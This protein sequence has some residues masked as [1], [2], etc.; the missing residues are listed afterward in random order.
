MQQGDE[1]YMLKVAQNQGVGLGCYVN[2]KTIL[3][4]FSKLSLGKSGYVSLVDQNGKNIVTVTE[5][6]I[7]RDSS[8]LD[9]GNYTFRQELS[10][11][12]FEIQIKISWTGVLNLM[13]G[14]VFALL[15]VAF[16]MVMAGSVL[17]FHLKTRILKPV[18]MFTENLQKYDKAN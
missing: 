4:P 18:A 16:L 1:V 9:T 11:S 5:K 12:P 2:L 8:K 10:Q 14:S 17:L 15:G 13:T 7:V 6:G 3:E